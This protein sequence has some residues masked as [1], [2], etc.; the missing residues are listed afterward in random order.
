MSRALPGVQSCVPKRSSWEALE[1]DAKRGGCL[2]E[3]E[4]LLL[5]NSRRGAG[6]VPEGRLPAGM[7]CGGCER[8]SDSDGDRDTAPAAPSPPLPPGNAALR[9][10]VPGGSQGWMRVPSWVMPAA[11]PLEIVAAA[12]PAVLLALQ[13]PR[14]SRSV[15]V[16]EWTHQERRGR[17]DTRAGSA[18]LEG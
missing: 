11:F 13:V 4:R 15:P 3:G 9:P 10:G 1:G 8:D 17:D 14:G 2:R 16:L 5:Q 7:E 12:F 18:P 6:A